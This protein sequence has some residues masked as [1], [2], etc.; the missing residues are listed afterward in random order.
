MEEIIKGSSKRYL[1]F[2]LAQKGWFSETIIAE[3]DLQ[4]NFIRSNRM[5]DRLVLKH[6]KIY[7]DYII[8]VQKP[9]KPLV[10]KIPSIKIT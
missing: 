3:A 1:N 6:E 5:E 4:V 8:C 10:T 7:M 9:K 2:V